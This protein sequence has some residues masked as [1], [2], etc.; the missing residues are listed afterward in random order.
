MF[1]IVKLITNKG[2]FCVNRQSIKKTQ[3]AVKRGASN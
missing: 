3:K 2:D 1:I